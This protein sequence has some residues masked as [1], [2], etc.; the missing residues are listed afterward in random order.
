MHRSWIS[1][2]F[3]L[4]YS[5]KPYRCIQ[6]T[7]VIQML[8]SLPNQYFIRSLQIINMRSISLSI[9]LG[10]TPLSLSSFSLAF[11]RLRRACELL[12]AS[13]C[14]FFLLALAS[15]CSRSRWRCWRAGGRRILNCE[16]NASLRLACSPGQARS[17]LVASSAT[18]AT[19][20]REIHAR[21]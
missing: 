19:S 18:S 11:A 2:A 3:L 13:C 10:M 16:S 12:R 1:D 8:G 20:A 21:D 9:S 6:S 7:Q 17:L 5:S 14:C 15:C 4:R